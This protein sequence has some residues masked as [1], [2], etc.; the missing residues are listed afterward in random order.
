[1]TFGLTNKG[2]KIK[3]LSD[4]KTE[5]ET[6]LRAKLG[7]TIN[8]LPQSVLGQLVGV[9]AEREAL[10]WELIQ[11][12]YNSQYPPTADGISLDLCAALTGHT[13]LNAVKSTGE[14][15]CTGVETTLIPQGSIVSVVNNPDIKFETIIGAEIGAG[16]DCVQKITFSNV[17]TG[18]YF[19]LVYSGEITTELDYTTDADDVAAA[20]N[21]LVGLS[22]VT[23]TGNFSIG[24][25]ITF[26]GS[27]G[28]KPQP[29]LAYE[30]NTLH[31]GGVNTAVT[32]T[33]LTDGEYPH[34]EIP[35]QAV[36][37]GALP[38][39]AGTITV[40]ETP[41]AG[42]YTCTN[43]VDVIIGRNIE[44]DAEFR[45]RREQT[46][47]YP[48][49][50]TDDAI[51]SKLRAIN[52]VAAVRV[53]SNREMFPDSDGRPPKSF[54]CIVKGGD[55]NKIAKT[56]WDN[57]PSGIEPYGSVH[58]VVVDSQGFNQDIYFSRPVDVNIY[59]EI[60]LEIDT[61]KYPDN[62]DDAITE[63]ILTYAGNTFSI[64]DDVITD[65]LYCP[66]NCVPGILNI[67][68]RIG[69]APNPT[70]DANIA[71]AVNA[72]AVFDSSRILITHV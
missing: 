34:V 11:A 52:E 6:T 53:I 15:Y 9:F 33:M 8:L 4:I 45:L 61:A 31:M 19:T 25:T 16:V 56:I 21:A 13:R 64:G 67:T 27:D 18:G 44:T 51:Y 40:I 63:S 3:R 14:I 48:G 17:P 42:W 5:I 58:V 38:A 69:T 47:A 35:I 12:V 54:E 22:G 55:D 20:L 30:T 72:I 71:I 50:C 28:Q 2:L 68:F 26:S 29:L 32:F 10:I 59:L 60:D 43:L 7:N 24:F 49:S 41:V 62:G 57:C 66:T 36:K 23:V 46:L 70:T 65:W 37:A 39:Y 1:M